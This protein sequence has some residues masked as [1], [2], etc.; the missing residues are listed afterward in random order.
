M[1]LTASR[2]SWKAILL[3][4]LVA[5]ALLFG[6]CFN[7]PKLAAVMRQWPA[8]PGIGLLAEVSFVVTCVA[9]V[10][11]RFHPGAGAQDLPGLRHFLRWRSPFFLVQA[12]LFLGLV[13]LTARI[14][15]G[16]DLYWSYRLR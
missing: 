6:L 13:C 1:Y 12:S 10:V 4:V 3:P 2:L 9:L 16:G 5:E 11:G 7:L 15:D 14:Q 8:E